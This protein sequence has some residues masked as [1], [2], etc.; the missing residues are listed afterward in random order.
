MMIN[1]EPE[2]FVEPSEAVMNEGYDNKNGV[3]I[4]R[5]NQVIKSP[6]GEYYTVLNHIGSGQF[7]SVYQVVCMSES[8]QFPVI[9]AMKITRSQHKFQKQAQHEISIHKKVRI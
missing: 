9:Y 7:G 6:N 4:V 8:S 1:T 2:M 5:R 3:M